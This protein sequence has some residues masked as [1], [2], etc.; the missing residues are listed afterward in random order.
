MYLSKTQKISLKLLIGAM[1]DAY[2]KKELSIKINHLSFACFL[3]ILY[4]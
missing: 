1:I 2:Y 4:I 3:L